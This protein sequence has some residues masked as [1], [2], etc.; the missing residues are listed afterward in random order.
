[1]T[2][3]YPRYV[4]LCDG[5]SGHHVALMRFLNERV[6]R[7][8]EFEFLFVGVSCDADKVAGV[9]NARSIGLFAHATAEDKA[10]LD[11]A[12]RIV[13]VGL[14]D[15]ALCLYLSRHKA[16]MGKTV[17]VLHGG[18]FYSLR[19]RPPLRRRVFYAVRKRL[20]PLAYAVATFTPADYERAKEYFTLPV[21]HYQA[22]LPWHFE[23]T[24]EQAAAPRAKDPRLV[25]VGHKAEPEDHT[26]EAL[27]LLAR[28]ADDDLEVIAPLS[29]GDDAYRDR[30]LARGREIFGDKFRPLL[31]WMDPVEYRT[32]LQDVTDFVI[33]VDRQAGTFN[34]NLML[35]LGCKVYLRRNTTLW[36]YFSDDLGCQVF[37]IDDI[38]HEDFATFTDFGPE[39]R[40]ANHDAIS[41]ALSPE[42]CFEC[43]MRILGIEGMQAGDAPAG[44]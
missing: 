22:E 37:N 1:M 13:V 36:D 30:V 7:P 15:P 34:V 42:S 29:Y 31:S 12:E 6:A 11:H 3:A 32:M 23:V 16:L 4:F 18:E 43:W 38:A 24:R 2:R 27:D 28:Y 21:R 8:E 40:L 5:T 10:L 44:E 41:A 25:L 33:D 20:V 17:V 9:A 39:Q 14:F 26:L 19:G 35:R